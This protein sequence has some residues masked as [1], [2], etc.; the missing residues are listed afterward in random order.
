MEEVDTPQI[1]ERSRLQ[2]CWMFLS[3]PWSVRVSKTSSSCSHTGRVSLN[4]TRRRISKNVR[5]T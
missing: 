5:C 1:L 3:T 4:Y 2:R